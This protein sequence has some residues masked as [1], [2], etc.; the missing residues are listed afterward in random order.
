[1]S[2]G[3]GHR[4]WP[5]SLRSKTVL[6]LNVFT[7]GRQLLFCTAQ[8]ETQVPHKELTRQGRAAGN[9]GSNQFSDIPKPS[10][11]TLPYLINCKSVPL[12]GMRQSTWLLPRSCLLS[13]AEQRAKGLSAL[14]ACKDYLCTLG[15]KREICLSVNGCHNA[16]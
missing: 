13:L 1:M 9:C 4:T 15:G 11:L 10:A 5:V 12:S 6:V 3:K 8:P 16:T 14:Q 2:Q 7:S